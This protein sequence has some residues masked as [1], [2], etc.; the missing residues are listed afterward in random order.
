MQTDEELIQKVF[1]TLLKTP[2]WLGKRAILAPLNDTV[3]N[4]NRTL[5]NSLPGRLFTY[6][7]INSV[8]DETEA[9]Q[10]P[11]EFH[12]SIEVSGLPPHQLAIKVG[13]PVMILRSLLPPVLMSGT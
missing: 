2:L 11:T 7:A 13:I 1:Q 4:I 3:K 9:I 5:I 12:N 8:V 10:Y 6:A